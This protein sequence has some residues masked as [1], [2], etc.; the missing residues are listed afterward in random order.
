MIKKKKK[1]YLAAPLFSQS[2]IEFNRKIKMLLSPYFDIYLPREDA[3]LVSQIMK[4]ESKDTDKIGLGIFKK[5]LDAMD[6]ADI[7]LI[8]L[9]GRAVDEGAAFELGYMFARKKKCLGLITDTRRPFPTGINPMLKYSCEFIFTS[10]KEL[11][12]WAKLQR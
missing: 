7:V 3:G 2:E 11:Q 12:N 9:D 5:D 8:I 6:S 1:L 10:L 4:K